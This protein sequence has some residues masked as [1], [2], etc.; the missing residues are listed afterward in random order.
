MRDK[1]IEP[2]QPEEAVIEPTVYNTTLFLNN[3]FFE[4]RI[5]DTVKSIGRNVLQ[6]LILRIS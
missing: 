6:N 5:E 2:R 1:L 4:L 3:K